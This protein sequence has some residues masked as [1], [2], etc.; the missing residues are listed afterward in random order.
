M[1]DLAYSAWHRTLGYSFFAMDV[2]F[3]EIRDDKP[4][5]VIE[6]SRCTPNHAWCGKCHSLRHH[7]Y[8][9]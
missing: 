7:I 9:T 5:A 8:E 4:V 2:D 6:A 3:V 1:A